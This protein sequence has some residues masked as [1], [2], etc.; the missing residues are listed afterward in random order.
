MREAGSNPS[1]EATVATPPNLGSVNRFNTEGVAYKKLNKQI[2]L[3]DTLNVQILTKHYKGVNRLSIKLK[4]PMFDL[5][6]RFVLISEVNL[7]R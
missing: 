1:K 4:H 2:S 5:I 7:Y 6:L 3:K